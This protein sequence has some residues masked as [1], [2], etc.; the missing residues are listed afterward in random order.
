[1]IKSRVR[2]LIASQDWSKW[3]K[4]TSTGDDTHPVVKKIKATDDE[5]RVEVYLGWDTGHSEEYVEA[6]KEKFDT[7]VSIVR[8]QEPLWSVKFEKTHGP[9]GVMWTN[10]WAYVIIP[11]KSANVSKN[12]SIYDQMNKIND[13]DSLNKNFKDVK[14]FTR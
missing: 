7:F 6:I 4:F 3:D 11:V 8:K 12:D 13:I 1:M 9:R 5:V 10:Y 14:K 2:E